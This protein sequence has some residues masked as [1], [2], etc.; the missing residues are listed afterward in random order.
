MRHVF[1]PND[2]STRTGK[3]RA[4]FFVQCIEKIHLNKQ[5]SPC[6]AVFDIRLSGEHGKCKEDLRDPQLRWKS[7]SSIANITKI[8]LPLTQNSKLRASRW[9]AGI[10]RQSYPLP[11]HQ[12][13]DALC[14]RG[15]LP[16]RDCQGDHD[17]SNCGWCVDFILIFAAKESFSVCKK[18]TWKGRG[19]RLLPL[20]DLLIHHL[21]LWAGKQKQ[22]AVVAG[23]YRS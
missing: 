6:A 13:A 21:S 18:M 10:A 7:W 19:S 20:H 22:G 8:F 1:W 3:V 9:V 4:K 23:K 2:K 5:W 17:L 14:R 12:H 15:G 11:R 16:L